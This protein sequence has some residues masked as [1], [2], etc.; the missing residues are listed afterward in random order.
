MYGSIASFSHDAENPLP[1]RADYRGIID[2][3]AALP[4]G[5]DAEQLLEFHAGESARYPE[6]YR[7]E[8]LQAHITIG[9]EVSANATQQ[10]HGHAFKSKDRLQIVQ[11]RLDG[12][13]FSRLAPYQSW[14]SFRDEARRLWAIY[15]TVVQPT[16]VTRVAVRYIN[17][18][19]L[20]LPFDDLTDYLRTV[21]EVAPDLPQGLAGYFMRLVI[22]NDDIESVLVINQA[23][24]EPTTE[25]MSSVILD[26]DLSRQANLPSDEDALWTI[27]DVL[28]ERKNEVF[29]ACITDRARELFR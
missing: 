1:Q 7:V 22:P 17:R 27:F 28:R 13:G 10:H 15:R 5:V 9:K 24:I 21:P 19:D 29:E 8:A 6:T 4:D 12:F 2:L 16:R 3:K 25:D 20:P 11:T 26:F 23:L 18:L 14:E